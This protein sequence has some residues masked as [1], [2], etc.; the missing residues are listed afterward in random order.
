M[1]SLY[2]I[3]QIS[4]FQSV[5]RWYMTTQK[6]VHP[7]GNLPTLEDKISG[8][9][10]FAEEIS[11]PDYEELGQYDAQKVFERVLE[12]RKRNRRFAGLAR[13]TA[14]TIGG[15]ST[16]LGFVDPLFFIGTGVTGVISSMVASATAELRPFGAYKDIL[17]S[18]EVVNK[19]LEH[20][21]IFVTQIAHSN[22]IPSA[23]K[24]TTYAIVKKE[25]G[26]GDDQSLFLIKPQHI[27]VRAV[28]FSELR[29]HPNELVVVKAGISSSTHAEDMNWTANIGLTF[30][31]S[32]FGP[33]AADGMIT[34]RVYADNTPFRMTNGN[35]YITASF[36]H[37]AN[38]DE[39]IAPP[40]TV[41]RQGV[42][43]T[44]NPVNDRN[45]LVIFLEEVQRTGR[46]LIF[47]GKSDESGKFHAEAV[48]DPLSRETYTLAVY[49]KLEPIDYV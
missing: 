38:L 29:D 36:G 21:Y 16:L 43:L 18:T 31:G 12:N 25:H 44:P 40:V 13:G 34:G 9:L 6:D 8:T 2:L 11:V 42:G 35:G 37:L 20:D 45:D 17:E 28:E 1:H 32:V 26:Y 4:I 39:R 23:V 10:R 19:A 5:F 15:G 27:D 3:V 48:A 14:M 46:D 30:H 24:D 41:K 22:L 47:L 7:I 33:R 49:Q